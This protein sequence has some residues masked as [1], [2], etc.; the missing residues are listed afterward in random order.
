MNL[1][2]QYLA[3]AFGLSEVGLLIAR[4]SRGAAR[5]VDF[6]SL[7]ALW[8]VIFVCITAATLCYFVLPFAHLDLLSL[9]QPL[10]VALVGLGLI[11]RWYAIIYLGR[12]FTVNIALAPG[13]HVVDTGPYR[14]VRHP[15]YT[16][17]ALIFTGLGL[18]YANWLS[19]LLVFV[20]PMIVLRRRIMIEERVLHGALGDA[21]AS[22]CARTRRLI[23]FVY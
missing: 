20:A 2:P 19:L 4:R 16:G 12:F 21:Y 3:A 6:G 15:S 1:D 22:Y 7:R 5:S 8:S 9:L 11:I 10:G 23:P 13:H 14:L 17:L 18:C